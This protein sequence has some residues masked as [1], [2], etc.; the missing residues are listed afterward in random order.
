MHP[1]VSALK[2]HKTTVVLVVLE[3]ALA[4]AIVTNALFLIGDRLAAMHMQSGV[5]DNELVW[6]QTRVLDLGQKSGRSDVGS[7]AAADLA[8]LRGM[9]G[10]ESVVMT[11]SLPLGGNYSSIAVYRHPGDEKGALSNVVEYLGTSGM[12]KTLGIDLSQGRDFRSQEYVNYS[13]FVTGGTQQTP[14]AA[15]VTRALA[16][17]LWPGQNP[18]GK[19]VYLD[20]SG[21]QPTYVVGVVRHL[22]NP[23]INKYQGVERGLI[24]PVKAVTGGMFV[25]RVRPDMRVAVKNA[26]PKVLAG[27]DATQIV[28]D[29]HIYADTVR[30]Y[31]HGDRSMIW[32]LLVVIGCLLAVTALGVVGL[33]GFW[34]QQRTKT[35]GV[36]RALGATRGDIL[37]YFLVEN[38]LI[39][40]VGVLTGLLGAVGLNLWLMRH[41]ELHHM[42]LIWLLPGAAL[43]M[44]LGQLAVLAPAL[45]AAAVPPVVATRTV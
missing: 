5:A 16:D 24:L 30:D 18:L 17:Q 21:K 38:C 32:L 1:I 14:T 39:V 34:V 10:V 12:L 22:L 36:R 37:R 31:F 28:T 25:L 9:P 15:I 27:V 11:N 35:I 20:S 26:L 8:A 3:I 43:L 13:P 2:H 29:D 33:S 7:V 19:P 6:A 45:R 41:Y 4:C 44:V 42:P 23:S 40:G